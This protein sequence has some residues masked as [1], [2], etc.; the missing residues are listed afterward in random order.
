MNRGRGPGPSAYPSAGGPISPATTL[1]AR[2]LV[3]RGSGVVGFSLA[4]A[5]LDSATAVVSARA[6]GV[7]GRGLFAVALT[8]VGLA[9]AV[10]SFGVPTV[11]RVRLTGGDLTL[12]RYLSVVP[13]HAVA[14]AVLAALSTQG[15]VVAGLSQ[16]G[17]SLSLVSGLVA[18][19]TVSSAFIFDGLNAFGRHQRVAASNTAGSAVALVGGL[20]LAATGPSPAA[21]L[22]ALALSQAVQTAVAFRWLRAAGAGALS[23]SGRAHMALARSGAAA[24]PY[25]VSTLATFRLDRYI[26]AAFTGVVGAGLYSVAATLSE[27]T[28]MLPLAFGQVLL[29]GRS[30]GQV[31]AATERKVRRLVLAVTWSALALLAVV[32]PLAVRTLFGASYLPA[33]TP[34]R[35]L[36]LAEAMLAAWLI[37]TRLLIASRR[38]GAAS[39]TTAISAMIVLAGNLALIPFFGLGGAAAASVLAYMAAAL[40]ARRMLRR[41]P[42]APAPGP[43]GPERDP[44]GPLA[45]ARAVPGT[46]GGDRAQ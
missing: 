2:T 42:R 35:I 34:L 18:L 45:G 32:A 10:S 29:F 21:Y 25:Q 15:L 23:Y 39:T 22:A 17:W 5:V 11:G 8:V 3:G 43:S 7:A 38:F 4:S 41:P 14:G 33:V 28:R 40:V 37:D 27:A 9:S 26:V 44:D 6:L 31:S 16:G 1:G 19:F 30:S 24:M 46:L 36:L 20:G 13:V 12:G